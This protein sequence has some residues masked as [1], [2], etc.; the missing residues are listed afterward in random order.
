MSI[1]FICF[2]ETE[3]GLGT[4]IQRKHK[5]TS[6]SLAWVNLFKNRFF[7]KYFKITNVWTIWCIFRCIDDNI[8]VLNK[9]YLVQVT[10]YKGITISFTALPNQQMTNTNKKIQKHVQT[11]M[12]PWNSPEMEYDDILVFGLSEH[13]FF[14]DSIYGTNKLTK[15]LTLSITSQP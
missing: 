1:P 14:C 5:N 2:S 11:T 12:M 9:T 15:T 6:F 8:L 7:F 4:N 10:R 3:H 13:L